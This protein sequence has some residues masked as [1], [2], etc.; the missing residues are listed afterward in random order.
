[1]TK[2]RILY[3]S[4][5]PKR[6]W[7]CFSLN[8]CNLLL[9]SKFGDFL[10]FP[11]CHNNFWRSRWNRNDAHFCMYKVLYFSA[12]ALDPTVTLRFSLGTDLLS[13]PGNRPKGSASQPGDR[14]PARSLAA[15]VPW[16]PAPTAAP[17]PHRTESEET[18]KGGKS[19]R[20]RA[21]LQEKMNKEK[22]KTKLRKLWIWNLNNPFSSHILLNNQSPVNRLEKPIK[23]V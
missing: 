4:C 16:S 2:R 19:D 22:K 8:W 20:L 13:C 3:F 23:A 14:W 10:H 6:K 17:G 7:I 18:Q 5:N 11:Q 15:P 12:Y 9:L 1:M 21:T